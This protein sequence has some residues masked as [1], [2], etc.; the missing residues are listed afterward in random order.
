MTARK[1]LSFFVYDDTTAIRVKKYKAPPSPEGPAGQ[2]VRVS[3]SHGGNIYVRFFEKR[4]WPN[5]TLHSLNVIRLGFYKPII[6]FHNY[7]GGILN[8]LRDIIRI[9]NFDQ[10]N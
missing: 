8:Y 6:R 9:V 2:Y 5:V 10:F 1:V 7:T 4:S 3:L